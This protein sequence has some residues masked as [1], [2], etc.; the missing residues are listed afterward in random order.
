MARIE[1]P[2]SFVG[3]FKPRDLTILFFPFFRELRKVPNLTLHT[4]KESR[5]VRHNKMHGTAE[6]INVCMTPERGS[7]DD[8]SLYS[9]T[10]LYVDSMCNH[11]PFISFISDTGPWSWG[12]MHWKWLEPLLG[13]QV[14]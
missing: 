14:G 12:P 7:G 9:L 4:N 5:S 13:S 11:L 6:E 2:R 8:S 10:N 3:K 1:K